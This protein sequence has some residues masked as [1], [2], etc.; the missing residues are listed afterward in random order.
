MFPQPLLVVI[1]GPTAV[2]KTAIAIEV[3]KRL[4]TE[5]LSADSRQCYKGMRIGT[6]QPDESE[7]REVKH[8]FIDCLEPH[9]H[10]TAADYESYALEVCTQVF[11]THRQL[12]VCGGTGLYIHA[13]CEGLDE[14]P[15]VDPEIEKNCNDLYLRN[16]ILWLQAAVAEEDP[17]FYK[18]GEIQNPMRLLRALIFIRSHGKSILTFRK[19]IPKRRPFDVLKIALYRDRQDLYRRIDNRVKDM[20]ASGL[21]AEADMLYTYKSHKNLQTV[22]YRELFDYR[23]GLYDRET[24][25]AKIQQHSRNYAKR[26]MTWFRKDPGYHWL[27][28]SDPQ[29]AE[30][31]LQ[32]VMPN[33]PL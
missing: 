26:Q 19:N 21:E 13:L 31:I 9:T 30:H 8:H 6:A 17:L 2:G 29:C 23:N 33:K 3:A 14:M 24:A 7:Q 16:G 27:D 4:N 22:G 32:R 25:I 11:K 28:A 20:I 18:Q 10:F 15:A 1:A 5:I 12:V